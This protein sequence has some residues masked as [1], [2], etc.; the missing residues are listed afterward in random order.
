MKLYS[1][2]IGEL[3]IVTNGT[4]IPNNSILEE[5]KRYNVKISISDYTSAIN[6]ISKNETF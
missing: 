1:N 2:N 6:Y 3:E 5:M 4:I